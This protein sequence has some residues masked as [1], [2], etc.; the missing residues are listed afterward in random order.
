MLNAGH[1]WR[2]FFWVVI[3]FAAVLFVVTLLTVE[4][5]SYDRN[6][7]LLAVQSGPPATSTRMADAEGE[8]EGVGLHDE[9]VAGSSPPSEFNIPRRK[10][11]LQ[12]LSIAGRVDHD[13]SFFGTMLRS[14]TY[15]LV[16]Q[17]LWVITSFGIFIGLG[18]F[19]INVTFPLLVMQPPYLWDIVSVASWG[20][21]SFPYHRNMWLTIDQR[22]ALD[23]SLL[24]HS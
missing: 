21:S 6:A 9:T 8:K 17:A 24:G 3:A 16:P 11:F 12:T 20:A 1:S 22:Q 23:Y 13:V 5:T 4:E 7:A 15:I 18:A 2:L 19:V 14:L 10:T